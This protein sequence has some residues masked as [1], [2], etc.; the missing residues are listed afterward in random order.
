MIQVREEGENHGTVDD[1]VLEVTHCHF[2]HV[3]LMSQRDKPLS[4]AHIKGQ[5]FKF[6]LLKRGVPKLYGHILKPQHLAL[7]GVAQWIEQQP[8]NQRVAGLI[9]SQGTRLDC[10]PG[11][12]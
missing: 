3:L 4:S 10:R 5:R 11:R 12:Q 9:P 8:V 2:S 7:A 6:H 1:L